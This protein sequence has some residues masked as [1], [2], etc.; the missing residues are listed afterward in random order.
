MIKNP[1]LYNC[2]GEG[3]CILLPS[4]DI[5]EEYDVVDDA[6]QYR[7]FK[8]NIPGGVNGKVEQVPRK[9]IRPNT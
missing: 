7:D 4:F 3:F 1:S 8:G 2:I 9:E 5:A 6:S